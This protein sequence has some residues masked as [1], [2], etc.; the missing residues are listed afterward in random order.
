[1]RETSTATRFPNQCAQETSNPA[2]PF[3]ALFAQTALFPSIILLAKSR[4]NLLPPKPLSSTSTTHL[5]HQ[6]RVTRPR[7]RRA[8]GTRGWGGGLVPPAGLQK[9]GYN[10][11]IVRALL[12]LPDVR[13]DDERAPARAV[14]GARPRADVRGGKRGMTAETGERGR[15]ETGGRSQQVGEQQQVEPPPRALVVQR[16]PSQ[17]PFGAG[18]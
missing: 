17:A 15:T 7:N 11:P 3:I 16:K 2:P 4:H 5:R 18:E 6:T 9:P 8:A 1:M 13:I 10:V 12:D 14:S